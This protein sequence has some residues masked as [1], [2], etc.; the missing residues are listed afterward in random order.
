MQSRIIRQLAKT[1]IGAEGE[2]GPKMKA[3]PNDKWR[4]FVTIYCQQGRKSAGRAYALAFGHDPYD[5]AKKNSCSVSGH[6]M[7]HDERVLSAMF[8]WAEKAMRSLA[9][10]ATN[11][12]AAVLDDPVAAA[13]DKINAAKTVADRVGLHARTE[14]KVT[15]EHLGDDPARL[16]GIAELAARLGLD[17]G[18]L[19]GKRLASRAPVIDLT[20]TAETVAN[21]QHEWVDD[22]Y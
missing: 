5:E 10:A 20:P 21:E 1:E 6:R 11:V 22:E 4:E 12:L 16:A 8:E 17:L 18:S 15:V 13:S 14:H 7:A 3:L 9:P 19:V 2:Y